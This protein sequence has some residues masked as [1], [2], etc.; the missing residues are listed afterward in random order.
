M[1][2]IQE[3]ATEI[4]EHTEK[5]VVISVLAYRLNSWYKRLRRQFATR[6]RVIAFSVSSVANGGLS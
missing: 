2:Q 5:S 4:T 3:R 1:I 6:I